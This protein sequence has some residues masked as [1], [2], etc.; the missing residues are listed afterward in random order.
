[1]TRARRRRKS[2]WALRRRASRRHPG[3][4]PALADEGFAGG[5]P[6]GVGLDAADERLGGGGREGDDRAFV[7]DGEA[8]GV[9]LRP[10]PE[11]LIERPVHAGIGAEGE[12]GGR[13]ALGDEDASRRLRDREGRQCAQVVHG[14]R[15]LLGL[16]MG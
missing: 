11:G 8:V 4:R 10:V 3:G 15:S 14:V 1:M 5:G 16:V 6:R 7:R 12:F 13:A 9:E 2:A